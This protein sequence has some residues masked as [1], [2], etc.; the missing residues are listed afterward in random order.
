MNW[1][2]LL[3]ADTSSSSSL[4]IWKQGSIVTLLPYILACQGA[5]FE[6]SREL[7]DE[8]DALQLFWLR[9]LTIRFEVPG[10]KNQI[11]EKKTHNFF[12]E[13]LQVPNHLPS[14]SRFF[15]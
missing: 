10:K 12:G 4:H 14:C 7:E 3:K 11:P 5:W 8:A 13:V 1:S 2:S 15:C 9:N 6:I